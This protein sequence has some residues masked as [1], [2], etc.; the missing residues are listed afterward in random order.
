MIL[1]KGDT[2]H[3]KN[4]IIPGNPRKFCTMKIAIIL[5]SSIMAT[6]LHDI[7]TGTD[8]SAMIINLIK[9]ISQETIIIVSPTQ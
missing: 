4:N 6:R 7:M 9:N 3:F 1:G 5:L 2:R 8:I